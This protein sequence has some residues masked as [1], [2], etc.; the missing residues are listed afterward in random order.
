LRRVDSG[1]FSIGFDIGGTNVKIVHLGCSPATRGFRVVHLPA[2]APDQILQLVERELSRTRKAGGSGGKSLL[3]VGIGCAGLIDSGSGM[4]LSSPNLP[5]WRE[6]P[7]AKLLRDRTGA[8][9]VVDNDA[10]CF[11]L[12]ESRLGAARGLRNALFVTLGTGVGGA[13]LLDGRIYRGEG[14]AGE[15]GHATVELDGPKCSCG[16]RGCLESLVGAR[17]VVRR[18]RR[19]LGRERGSLGGGGLLGSLTPETI[20]REARAGREWAI[21]TFRETGRILGVA[22]G[23][24]ANIFCPEAIVLGGGISMAGKLILEPAREA[25]AAAAMEP[26]SRKVKLLRA[27]LGKKAG[28]VGA[29]LQVYENAF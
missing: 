20:A 26:V 18:G 3:G 29:A 13:L 10:N 27:R 9:V 24:L 16:N 4:V 7:L 23:G 17:A 28:A 1:A 22:L 21:E 19:I 25:I 12:A 2:P 6:V 15:L 8:R 11:A 5:L 14:F